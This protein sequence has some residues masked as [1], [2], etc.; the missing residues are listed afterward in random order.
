M[1]LSALI[2]SDRA[3]SSSFSRT[4][5][6]PTPLFPRLSSSPPLPPA[7]PPGGAELLPSLPDNAV[8]ARP[9]LPRLRV[10]A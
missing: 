10:G 7:L 9:L 1:P 4:P 5:S 2:P 8:A 6:L 3:P